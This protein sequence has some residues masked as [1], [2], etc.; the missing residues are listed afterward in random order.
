MLDHF[1]VHDPERFR[2]AFNEAHGREVIDRF[3]LLDPARMEAQVNAALGRDLL[4]SGGPLSRG[5]DHSLWDIVELGTA[6][7][8]SPRG[9]TLPPPAEEGGADEIDPPLVPP[10]PPEPVAVVEMARVVDFPVAEKPA[11]RPASSKK[12]R[13]R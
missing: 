7:A 1:S 5:L 8:A 2:A 12:K 13:R 6:L 3:A 9:M 11:P 10:D 4:R